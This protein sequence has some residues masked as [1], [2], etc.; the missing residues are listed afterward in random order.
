MTADARVPLVSATV[1]HVWENKLVLKWQQNV[2]VAR[3]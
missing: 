1:Q 3:Y 2:L